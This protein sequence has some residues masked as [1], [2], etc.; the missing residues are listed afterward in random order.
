MESTTPR[1]NGSTSNDS[2]RIV[3]IS[4]FLSLVCLVGVLGNLLVIW[5]ILRHVKKLSA[6]LLLILNLVVADLLTAV[7]I[8][9][10]IYQWTI[11]ASHNGLL[12]A[13]SY[14]IL[15]FMY[16]SVFS[17]TVISVLRFVSVKHT[18]S[19]QKWQRW[20]M[21]GKV[22]ALIWVSAF[23]LAAPVFTDSGLNRLYM[24]TL[25]QK[26]EA[27]YILEILVGF[28]IPFIIMCS[29]YALVFTKINQLTFQTKNKGGMVI[30]TVVVAFAVFWLPYQ[31]SNALAISLFH[32]DASETTCDFILKMKSSGIILAF[33]SSCVNPI[34]YAC[35]VQAFKSGFKLSN[36]ATLFEEMNTRLTEK[37]DKTTDDVEE[38]GDQPAT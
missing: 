16:I 10:I 6:T 3:V 8:P 34:L 21:T 12:K 19:L 25:T 7:I 28:L 15:S 23:I 18:M 20:G 31:I 36:I 4:F 5:I 11:D 2:T 37:S 1:Q 9:L 27:A 22:I 32:R 29:C 35:T 13:P 30:L 33:A 24:T 26:S 38:K 17:I 14:L